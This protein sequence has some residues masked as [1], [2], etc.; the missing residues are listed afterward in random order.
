MKFMKTENKFNLE[1][2]CKLD[3]EFMKTENKQ[4]RKNMN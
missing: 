4:F 3:V 2:R 1:K